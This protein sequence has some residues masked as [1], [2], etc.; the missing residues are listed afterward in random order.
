[1]VDL[2]AYRDGDGDEDGTWTW[3]WTWKRG[4]WRSV[5]CAKYG[6][7]TSIFTISTCFSGSTASSIWAS[8]VESVPHQVAAI[9]EQ[10]IAVG[11]LENYRSFFQRNPDMNRLSN[12]QLIHAIVIG[13]AFVRSEGVNLW[14]HHQRVTCAGLSLVVS[15]DVGSLR[16]LVHHGINGRLIKPA[17]RKR[18]PRS[19]RIYWL[20]QRGECKWGD[21]AW[22]LGS[23]WSYEQCRWASADITA[24]LVYVRCACD[25]STACSIDQAMPNRGRRRFLS[26]PLTRAPLMNCNSG[27]RERFNAPRASHERS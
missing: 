17:I 26:L 18:S 14:L 20:I 23:D 5:C 2:D 22:H 8:I 12:V 4:R 1:M 13:S 10:V 15:R 24:S 25:D 16:D 21:R 7:V 9:A 3:T 27:L 19:C 6:S 11:G